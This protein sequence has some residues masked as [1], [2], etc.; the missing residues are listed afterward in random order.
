LRKQE[1][2]ASQRKAK[3]AYM[4]VPQAMLLGVT[5][6]FPCEDSRERLIGGCNPLFLQETTTPEDP[7]EPYFFYGSFPEMIGIKDDFICDSFINE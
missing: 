5:G 7:K 1:V 3:G 4:P 2:T 6:A